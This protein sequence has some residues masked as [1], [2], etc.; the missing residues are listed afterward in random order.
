MLRCKSIF[1]LFSIHFNVKVEPNL[2]S[3]VQPRKSSIELTS[4]HHIACFNV[5]CD[6]FGCNMV[7]FLHILLY[8]QEM[9]TQLVGLGTS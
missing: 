5:C 2:K 7:V 6:S 3:F 4:Q 8:V 1:L 9:G